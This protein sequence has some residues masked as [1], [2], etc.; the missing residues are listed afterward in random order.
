MEK[1]S[2]KRKRSSAVAAFEI[3]N[4]RKLRRPQRTLAGTEAPVDSVYRII[5]VFPIKGRNGRTF[6]YRLA[7]V[8]VH[9]R[10]MD[11]RSKRFL[12]ELTQ[13]RLKHH[14]RVACL[15]S[16][17]K[18]RAQPSGRV[19]VTRLVS[20]EVMTSRRKVAVS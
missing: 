16:L 11:L 18:A 17:P 7:Q 4:Y 14:T 20:A 2:P 8:S 10:T 19:K 3:G 13:W 1:P 12:L 6:L 9:G 5:D 15:V